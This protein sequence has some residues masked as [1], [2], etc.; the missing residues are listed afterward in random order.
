MRGDKKMVYNTDGYGGHNNIGLNGYSTESFNN[1]VI[2]YGDYRGLKLPHYRTDSYAKKD[3]T[4][5]K[6]DAYRDGIQQWL[7]GKE[8]KIR[9]YSKRYQMKMQQHRK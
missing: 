1:D 6:G 3:T 2:K 4:P 7:R 5:R 8:T 9:E